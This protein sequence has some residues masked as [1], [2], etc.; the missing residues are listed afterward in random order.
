MRTRLVIGIIVLAVGFSALS[1]NF[2]WFKINY[3]WSTVWNLWPLLLILWGL[4][5]LLPR[6]FRGIIATLTVLGLCVLAFAGFQRFNYGWQIN[7]KAVINQQL[8]AEKPQ[9]IARA[10]LEFDS[11]AGEFIIS[12]TTEKLLAADTASSIG[13]YRLDQ[14]FSGDVESLRLVMESG[15]YFRLGRNRNRVDLSLSP[16]P[17]WDL[18]INVGAASGNFDLSGYKVNRTL[19][20]SGASSLTLKLSGA[21]PEAYAEVDTGASSI[22]IQVPQDVAMEIQADTG[23]ARSEF[24]GLEQV[25]DGL[26][27]SQGFDSAAKKIHIKLRAGASN[28]EVTKY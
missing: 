14:S 15:G 3:D 4:T 25:S 1:V 10:N 9:G 6:P 13:R 24:Q 20:K 17:V 8:S 21:L 5:F 2:G 27:R 22:R 19:I 18:T 23:L 12:G 7:P 16:D 28:L 26:Y 11:G